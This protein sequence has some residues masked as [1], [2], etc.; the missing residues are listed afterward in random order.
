MTPQPRPLFR[1]TLPPDRCYLNNTAV[2]INRRLPD[3]T[4]IREEDLVERIINIHQD[5]LV[6]AE[7]LFKLAADIARTSSRKAVLYMAALGHERPYDRN[8]TTFARLECLPTT[9]Q[10][11]GDS[12]ATCETCGNDYDKAFQVTMNGTAHTF[13]SFECAIH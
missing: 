3:D 8:R 10:Q 7:N 12:M 6:L 4:S 13:D 9:H 1:A 5:L 2:R 11:K